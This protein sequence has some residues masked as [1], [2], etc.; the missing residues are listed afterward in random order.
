VSASHAAVLPLQA[1]LGKAEA[2]WRELAEEIS[3]LFMETSLCD[4]R[5]MV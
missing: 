4:T 3:K 5:R 1:A 2:E